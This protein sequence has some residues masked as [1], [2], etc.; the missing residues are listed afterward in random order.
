[1][2]GLAR[3]KPE[4]V[5]NIIRVV[6]VNMMNNFGRVKVS[7]KVLLHY[8]SMFKDI[9]ASP[10]PPA[11]NRE[12]MI[13]HINKYIAIIANFTA[14]IP[15]RALVSRLSEHWIVLAKES[16]SMHGIFITANISIVRGVLISKI[17]RSRRTAQRAI[18]R[19][20]AFL[21]FN[22]FSALFTNNLLS[23]RLASTIHAAKAIAAGE[24]SFN[25]KS[26]V[27][28]F[29]FQSNAFSWHWHITPIIKLV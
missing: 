15:C 26:F 18:F 9:N 16:F 28:I 2:F 13:W 3:V 27:A 24:A 7:M 8:D 5:Y 17:A 6:T 20:S 25:F 4:I 10:I 22:F 21:D 1:M 19:L 29:A 14:S 12:R 23:S 11:R